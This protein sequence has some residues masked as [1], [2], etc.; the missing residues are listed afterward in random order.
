MKRSLIATA[1]LLLISVG[2]A[3]QSPTPIAERISTHLGRTTRTT[4]FSNHVAVVSIQSD[5]EDYVNRVT[6]DFDE[7]M[8]YL[9]AILVAV[10]EIGAEPIGSDVESRESVTVLIVHVGPEAPRVFRYS[11]LSSLSLPVSKIASVMDDVQNRALDALPGEW[12]L[13][14]W[15]PAVGDCVE[16]RQGGE[17]C[18]QTVNEDGTIVLRRSDIAMTIG[19]PPDNRADVILKILEPNP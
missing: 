4:L 7:Y 18:V 17:A 3:A 11:P 15:T 6:L 19:V 16:L 12:E 13:E 5:T 10:E 8:V 9:Q 2:A 14:K 1:A